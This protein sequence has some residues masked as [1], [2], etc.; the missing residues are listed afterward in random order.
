MAQTERLDGWLKSLGFCYLELTNAE[1]VDSP[2]K[3]IDAIESFPECIEAYRCYRSAKRAAH[4]YEL[5]TSSETAANP[6]PAD[7]A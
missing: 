1:V 6:D 4:K 7:P 2:R 3:V 5:T